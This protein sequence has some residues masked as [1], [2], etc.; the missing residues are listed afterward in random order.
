MRVE[1][2]GAGV[3]GLTVAYEIARRGLESGVAVA[4]VER[5]PAPGRGCSRYAGGMIAP[6][7]EL[8]TAEPI[9]AQLGQEA[10][11]FWTTDVP[12]ATTNGSLV[13]AAPRERAELLDFSRRTEN[14]QSLDVAALGELEPDLAERFD[15]ALFF[16][17]EAHLD[18]ALAMTALAERLG[19][20]PNV[21]L[22][23]D[24]SP[25]GDADWTVD[26]RGFAARDAFKNLRGVK[27]EM[28]V[29]RTREIT[30]S[31]PVRML[32][33]KRPAYVVP[34]GQGLFMIG[35]TMIENEEQPRVT[36]RSLVELVNTAY[37]IHP[38]FA[39]AEIVETGSDLRPAFPDNLP[40]LTR[41]GKTLYVNGLFRHG[42][43]LAPALAR[44]AARMLLEDAW[45]EE[46][47]NEYP[48]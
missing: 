15:S 32:H 30:L 3:A 39:E 8:E 46:I 2:V 41:R 44:R 7:C 18:P 43:L 22:R 40:R 34:R 48:N 10:L 36:A 9:V 26:C 6:W 16:A 13:V 25:S 12:V 28:L 24:A 11:D 4:L 21:T 33:P 27:G 45:F 35:A 29:L 37:A 17:K 19:E 31:R 47:C 1:V 5:E 38:A 42:F 23:F 20:L 14:F